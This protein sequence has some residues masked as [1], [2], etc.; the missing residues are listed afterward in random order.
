MHRDV[1][2]S[3]F[4]EKKNSEGTRNCKIV[5]YP[6]MCTCFK[7]SIE[8]LTWQWSETIT[9]MKIAPGFLF[10]C[11]CFFVWGGVTHEKKNE[12]GEE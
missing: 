2:C 12:K 1:N 7:T 8:W 9:M 11:F 5:W 6:S 10:V 3:H 4:F